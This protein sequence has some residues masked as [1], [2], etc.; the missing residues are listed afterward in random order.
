[1]LR[2]HIFLPRDRYKPGRLHVFDATGRLI[3]SDVPVLG[4]A[5]NGRAAKAGNP[6]RAPMQPFGDT[7]TGSYV[8]TRR[9]MF[10]APHDRLGKGWFPIEGATGDALVACTAGG[11]TGLGLHAGRGNDRLVPTYGCLRVLDS[12]FDALA[13]LAGDAPVQIVVEEAGA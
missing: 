9:V 7:P 8:P 13:A 11:R 12:D 6:D 3:H 10:G 2:F 5:D 1:M 4:K